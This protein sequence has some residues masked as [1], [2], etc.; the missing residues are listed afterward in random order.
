V[1]GGGVP[2]GDRHHADYR[3]GQEMLTFQK[4]LAEVLEVLRG[5]PTAVNPRDDENHFAYVGAH[6]LDDL[7][8]HGV[9]SAPPEGAHYAERCVVGEW[10]SRRGLDDGD[11]EMFER[12]AASA[13]V[14]EYFAHGMASEAHWEWIDLLLDQAQELSDEPL[15]WGAVADGL[16]KW[17]EEQGDRIPS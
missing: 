17:V 7:V 2:G 6:D 11:L 1:A 5:D 8:E 14:L 9:V 4:V 12:T 13:L 3:K 10:A 16:V 15:P